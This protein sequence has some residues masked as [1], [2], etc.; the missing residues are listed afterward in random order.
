MCAGLACKLAN[1]GC[2][3]DAFGGNCVGTVVPFGSKDLVSHQAK[4]YIGATC[5]DAT[6]SDTT[7][8]VNGHP[9]ENKGIYMGKLWT[10]CDCSDQV[11]EIPDLGATFLN[12]TTAGLNNVTKN[13]MMLAVSQLLPKINLTDILKLGDEKKE[14]T[15]LFP[16][17]TELFQIPQLPTITMPGFLSNNS[18]NSSA[19]ALQLP[20]LQTLLSQFAT[21]INSS[22]S[23]SS[24]PEAATPESAAITPESAAITPESA[25]TPVTP[26]SLQS[27]TA[28]PEAPSPGPAPALAAANSSEGDNSNPLAGI[29]NFLS[30]ILPAIQAM[31]PN[32]TTSTSKSNGSAADGG[33]QVAQAPSSQEL[34]SQIMSK[35]QAQP[36][37]SEVTHSEGQDALFK[38]TV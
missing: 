24:T 29:K 18:S 38:I 15:E 12:F 5:L 4:K 1:P 30:S 25:A 31:S 33:Q 17:F 37:D 6:P 8:D 36:V 20:S 22:S 11:A 13:D 23:S 27:P 34:M 9:A 10:I 32:S 3:T 7:L 16:S 19:P 21:K 26:A 2:T 14:G 28:T 35:H